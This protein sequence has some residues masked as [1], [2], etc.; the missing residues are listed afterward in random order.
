MRFAVR[1]KPGA[2]RDFV[3]GEHAGAL[4]VSVKAPAVEGKANEAV[5][6]VLAKAL[7]VRSRDVVV[8]QGERG[9]DKVIELDGAPA[10]LETVL[11]A[12]RRR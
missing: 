2:K 12:L 10:G 1:V 6:K 11:S 4:I 9:R 5:R 7:G 3:G 8:V